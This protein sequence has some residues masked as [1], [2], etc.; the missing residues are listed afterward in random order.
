MAAVQWYSRWRPPLNTRKWHSRW[1]LALS[2]RKWGGRFS[3][4]HVARNAIWFRQLHLLY[5]ANHSLNVGVLGVTA[6]N[7]KERARRR[8]IH[9]SAITI[10]QMRSFDGT[11][12]GID[13]RRR[14]AAR[15]AA[16]CSAGVLTV[17]KW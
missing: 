9:M 14:I 3:E 11:L 8:I 2:A 7:A 15:L 1:G 12:V 13:A 4:P 16:P 10:G 17:K 6:R 5:L